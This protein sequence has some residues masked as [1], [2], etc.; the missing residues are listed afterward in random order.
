MAFPC[1]P[2][3]FNHW[4]DRHDWACALDKYLYSMNRADHTHSNQ[5]LSIF[6]S[7]PVL[8]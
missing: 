3:H 4:T 5:L 1:V 7:S 2:L 6:T 8:T